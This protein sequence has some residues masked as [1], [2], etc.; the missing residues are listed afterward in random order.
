MFGKLITGAFRVGTARALV[1]RALAEVTGVPVA[2]VAHRLIGEWTPSRDVLRL[3][4]RA[5]VDAAA[6]RIGRIRSS[7]RTRSKA[8][9]PTLGSVA[10][11]GRRNGNGT[12]SARSSSAAT[13]ASR[14]G[15]AAR[16]S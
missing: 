2:D 9:P 11:H 16:I 5:G 3:D 15:R 10:D 4:P 7:S 8:I 14:S 12:A 1:H 13:T 6:A